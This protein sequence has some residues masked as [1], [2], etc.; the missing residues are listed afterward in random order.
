MSDWTVKAM[1][2]PDKFLLGNSGGG[3]IN[4]TASESI[5]VSVHLAQYKKMKEL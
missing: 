3:I 4:N 1:G 2:L 5:I